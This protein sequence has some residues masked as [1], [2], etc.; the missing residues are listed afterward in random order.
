MLSEL[1][2]VTPEPANTAQLPGRLLA[3]LTELRSA[4]GDL[5]HGIQ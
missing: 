5:Q 2:G 1:M 4:L 3:S